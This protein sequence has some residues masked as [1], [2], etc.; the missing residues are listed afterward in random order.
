M[1]DN[2]GYQSPVELVRDTVRGA[3]SKCWSDAY[4]AAAGTE[5][6]MDGVNMDLAGV[7]AQEFRRCIV[8][9]SGDQVHSGG[10]AWK[11]FLETIGLALSAKMPARNPGKPRQ[12]RVA[13][14]RCRKC[15]R[16]LTSKCVSRPGFGPTC[17]TMLSP[18]SQAK[19]LEESK[20]VAQ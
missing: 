3:I 4:E 10:D 5:C 7:M 6:G 11:H 16:P 1:S 20:K 8:Q 12:S 15:R 9:V 18:E 13:V 17:W 14:D 19:A 2:D